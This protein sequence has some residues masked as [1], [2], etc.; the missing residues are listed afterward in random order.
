MITLKLLYKSS[1]HKSLF[2]LAISLVAFTSACKSKKAAT[3]VVNPAEEVTQV[4][5]KELQELKFANLFISACSERMKG[6]L[7]DALTFL[8]ECKKVNPNSAPLHFEFATVYKLQGA[9]ELALF[10][11]QEAAGKDQ[12][13]EWY[14]LLLIE[15]LIQAK[16][17][18]Q[19]IKVREGLVKNFPQKSEY[20]EELA[21][22]YAIVGQYDKAIKI[23]SELEKSFGVNEQLTLNKVKLLKSQK[24]TLE[25]E[26]EYKNLIASNPNEMR[27]QGYLA[28]YYM[29]LQQFE[30]AKPLYDKILSNEPNN[31][32][33]NLALHDYYQLKNDYQ[34][35]FFYL[36]KA[37]ENP[38]LEVGIKTEIIGQYYKRSEINDK[39]A[40]EKGEE[41]AKIFLAVHPKATES[42][43]LYADFLRLQNKPTEA[44]RYYYTAC[45]N[46]KQNFRIWENLLL[47]ENQTSQYDSLQKH[48]NM[49]MELFPSAPLNY[50]LN[51]VANM[52]LKNYQKATTSLKDGLELVVANKSLMLDFLSTLGDAYYNLNEFSKSDKAFED[53]LK[54]D[55]DNTYVLNNYA[56]Y[57]SLRNVQLEKAEKLSKRTLEL[58]PN[59]RNYMDTYGWILYQQKNY[60]Q[61]EEWLSKASKSG[62]KNPN[63]LEHHGDALFKLGKVEEAITKWKEAA[64]AGGSSK[65]LQTKIKS[66]KT[67]D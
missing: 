42:N 20:K 41:L 60:L 48:S 36:K 62:S 55:S 64:E 56:Y 29:E 23:Y 63:I 33:V 26:N 57:L 32:N 67:N 21:I 6:N 58:R 38:D 11:A 61:A 22:D 17:Y 59:D 45:M 1:I 44:S 37:I 18:P 34:S 2:F 46:N 28:E 31:P 4:E 13:N 54:I 14:Q 16:K 5:S 30:K 43:A 50:L 53:A 24:K 65:E 25:I 51:G 8:E 15:C 49:A 19:A 27:F 40:I 39:D 47:L 7:K 35:A 52:Q 9:K 3:K 12:K 10:H 66:K